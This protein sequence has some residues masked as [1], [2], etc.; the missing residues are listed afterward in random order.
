MQE[1]ILYQN[2]VLKNIFSSSEFIFQSP[3]TISQISFAKKSLVENNVLLLGDAAGMITPLCGNGMS[4]ALHSSK[5]ATTL[6]DLFLSKKI[7]RNKMETRYLQLWRSHF[8]KRIAAGRIL[9]SFFGSVLLSNLFVGWFKAFPSL[10]KNIIKKT[11][12]KAF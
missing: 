5:M 1:T 11:H 12:G 7:D 8:S 6:I 3:V 9:Q 10:A 4:M 2:P